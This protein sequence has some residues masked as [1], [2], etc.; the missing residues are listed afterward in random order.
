[1]LS[2]LLIKTFLNKTMLN[3]FKKQKIKK[4]KK[5]NPEKARKIA[6]KNA[7]KK[8]HAKMPKTFWSFMFHFGKRYKLPILIM[9]LAPAWASFASVIEAYFIK[10]IINDI[11]IS[12]L[13]FSEMMNEFFWIILGFVLLPISLS[14]FWRCYSF[15]ELKYVKII[16]DVTN[17]VLE[18]VEN[19]SFQYFQDNMSGSIANK[20]N[21]LARVA[22][23][24]IHTILITFGRAIFSTLI[25]VLFLY[26]INPILAWSVLAWVILFFLFSLW[27]SKRAVKYSKSYSEARSKLT[28]K[29]VDSVSNIMTVK[30]FGRNK[31]ESSYINKYVTESLNKFKDFLWFR[32]KDF[33]VKDIF[34]FSFNAMLLFILLYLSSIN[35]LT[36]GDF[37]FVFIACSSV[38]MNLWDVSFQLTYFMDQ[39]GVCN[40]A[41]SIISTKQE[42][43]DKV[44]AKP[45][46]IK[47]GTIEFKNVDFKYSRK[48][49]VFKNL[50]IKIKAG[51]RVGL[52]GFSGSGKS[53]F[54]KLILRYYDI[55]KGEILIDGKNVADVKQ[56]S[57]RHSIGM[58][59]QDTSLFHR[60]IMENIRY[61]N[62]EVTDA[63]VKKAAKMARCDEFIEKLEHGYDTKVGERGIKLS[64]GQRQRIAIARAI[65][66][67]AKILILDEATSS[68]DS[69]TEQ[70]I[71][72]HLNTMT[73]GRTTIAIAHRL[74]TLLTMDKI[75]V[76][77][78][79]KIME[80]G[81][82]KELLKRKGRYMELWSMQSDGFIKE[83]K[84]EVCQLSSE[85][86]QKKTGIKKKK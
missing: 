73:K 83:E 43:V 2:I 50:N 85:S 42:V 66:K 49:P 76:F 33:V 51:E 36:L 38:I 80:V 17:E 32:L 37:A 56:C 30:L 16:K 63:E 74:S 29:V 9:A 67:D 75:I 70:C 62:L 8:A 24:I 34:Y 68:L 18:Y 6:L 58:I 78:N 86:G 12:G 31:N 64:G 48:I 82:H 20:I 10:I 3:L 23:N 69:I 52:V 14:I 57:L 77:E 79:G 25:T 72:D 1:M 61:G 54:V 71:Q 65:L 15:A 84:D 26:K 13:S 35:L 27:L 55:N 46:Q 19:H 59:P 40:Q 44:R 11:A 81:S 21:D 41:L 28:G 60:T 22:N 53:T 45:I 47:K 4:I 5:L 7:T 39:V